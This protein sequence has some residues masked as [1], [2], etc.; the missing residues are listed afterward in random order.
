MLKELSGNNLKL[1]ILSLPKSEPKKDIRKLR[2]EVFD[3]PIIKDAMNLFNSS[4]V[5]VRALDDEGSS[6]KEN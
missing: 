5:K 4:I 2:K 1:K 6:G 3:E